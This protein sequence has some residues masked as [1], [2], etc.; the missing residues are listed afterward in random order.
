MFRGVQTT[1]DQ[2]L[3]NGHVAAITANVLL[4]SWNKVTW[5]CCFFISLNEKWAKYTQMR[6]NQGGL[7]AI[8][9]FVEE[10]EKI[11]RKLNLQ[12]LLKQANSCCEVGMLLNFFFDSADASP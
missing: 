5:A 11:W 3:L 12:N 2:S 6:Q 10:I 1:F 4:G 8:T 7:V 9:G